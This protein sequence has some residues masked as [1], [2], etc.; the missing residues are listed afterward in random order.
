MK[1]QMK[2]AI[3]LPYKTLLKMMKK[4]P[5]SVVD[6]AIKNED[7]ILL[8]KRN[9]PPFKGQWHFPGGLVAYNERLSDTAKRIAK[10]E[11]GL[12]VKVL[13]FHGCYN[14]IN[15]DPRGHHISHV[16]IVKK[17][18][19]KLRP[20]WENSDFKFVKSVPKNML[21]FHKQILRNVLNET[22]NKK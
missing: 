2:H 1:K 14:L 12:K 21:Y 22:K 5:I 4:I 15:N 19:G 3:K 6:V 11:T 16:F 18:G 17:I 8:A 10:G 7:G 13:K 9:I 20:N